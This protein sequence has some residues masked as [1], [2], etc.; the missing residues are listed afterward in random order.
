MSK[1]RTKKKTSTSKKSTNNL[2]KKLA[3]FNF[4]KDWR[5]TIW[6][7]V[8]FI[9][10]LFPVS[11]YVILRNYFTS[12]EIDKNMLIKNTGII[13][14]KNKTFDLYQIKNVSAQNDIFRGGF[15]ILTMQDGTVNKLP[16]IK[17]SS[18]LLPLLREV[19]HSA[20][21]QQHVYSHELMK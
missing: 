10:P 4:E 7:S 21:S 11:I 12:Y 15:L 8:L 20:R 18:K 1:K 16:Y 9:L 13:F 5:P 19:S 3:K 17:N 6:L 2:S 14:K